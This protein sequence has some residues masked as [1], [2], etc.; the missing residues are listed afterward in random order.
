[1]STLL[2]SLLN[3]LITRDKKCALSGRSAQENDRLL[4]QWYTLGIMLTHE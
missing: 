2:T 3:I 4:Y 1:M